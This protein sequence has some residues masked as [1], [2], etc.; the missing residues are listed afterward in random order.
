MNVMDLT[1]TKRVRWTIG[2]QRFPTLIR[3]ICITAYLSC[4]PRAGARLVVLPLN[5]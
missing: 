2:I 4:R 1:G 3:V 5:P